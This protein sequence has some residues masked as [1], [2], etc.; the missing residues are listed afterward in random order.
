MESTILKTEGLK[1][2]YGETEVLRGIDIGIPRNR[3]TAVMGPSGCGKTTLIRCFNR[4]HEMVPGARIEGK[5]W[6]EGRDITSMKLIQVRRMVGMVFQKPNPFP[7]MSIYDN[8]LAGYRLSGVKLRKEEA[9]R[10]VEESL[11]KAALW[12]EVKDALHRRGT[13][14]SGGQQQRLCIARALAVN[15]RLLLMDEPTSALDPKAAHRVEELISRLK[16]TVTVVVVTHNV[17]QA[18]RVADYTA[19]L[20]LGELIEFG[21]TTQLFT[22]PQDPRTEEY[23]TGKFG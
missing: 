7:T 20:Y 22:A 1:A 6:L 18:G 11:K 15:P 23:L 16:E 13:F 21:P 17:A 10:I 8:V 2:Y 14:L 3:V 4:M 12:E 19:F 9:Q 5:I